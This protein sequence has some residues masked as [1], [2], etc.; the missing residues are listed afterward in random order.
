MCTNITM[1]NGVCA[2]GCV[3]IPATYEDEFREFCQKSLYSGDRVL[4][5]VGGCGKHWQIRQHE[6]FNE[7]R[8]ELVQIAT[9]EFNIPCTHG[10]QW[11]YRCPMADNFHFQASDL[12]SEVFREFK[13]DVV[14]FAFAV[15][16]AGTERYRTIGELDLDRYVRIGGPIDEQGKIQ[17]PRLLPRM[18][19]DAPEPTPP[20]A[21]NRCVRVL[22]ASAPE[23][24][25]EARVLRSPLRRRPRSSQRRGWL[26]IC[27]GRVGTSQRR[28]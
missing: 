15:D 22:P 2:N 27:C 9:N 21:A 20:E 11:W 12:T 24:P 8:D 23:A 1:L 6:K 16:P 10:M 3:K 4:L 5:V 25:Q 17:V 18:F 26:I 13:R 14:E 28:G 19:H 7:L